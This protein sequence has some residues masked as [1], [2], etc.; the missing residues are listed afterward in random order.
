MAIAADAAGNAYVTGR[1]ES[2]DFPA[3]PAAFQTQP[4]GYI[5]G[6]NFGD[7]YVTKLD[8][9]GNL[10]YSSLLGGSDADIGWAIAVDAYG[11]AHV[12]GETSS[13]DFPT[14]SS[15]MQAAAG[16][17]VMLGT[18]SSDGFLAKL[19][20]DGSGL[21]YSTYVGGPLTDNAR[22]IA[23]DSSGNA[24]ITGQ[25][26]DG[27]LPMVNGRQSY[28]GGDVY[29]VSTDGGKTFLPQRYG[30]AAAQV[31]TIL[32]DPTVPSLVYA[33]TLQGVIATQPGLPVRHE[34]QSNLNGASDVY[35]VKW[36]P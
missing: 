10:V 28:L 21:V 16:R 18:V 20:A 9:T 27:R 3:T 26:T 22:A 24:Y 13:L 6:Y 17:Q 19:T 31:T 36:K 23:I 14:A 4:G 32:F 30:L 8:P 35:L 25:T 33:G 2:P 29:L 34:T 11:Q 15:A 12:A 5:P 7:A 1:T